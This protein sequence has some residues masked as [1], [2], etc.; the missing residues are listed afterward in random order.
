MMLSDDAVYLYRIWH[1]AEAEA[2]VKVAVAAGAKGAETGGEVVLQMTTGPARTLTRSMREAPVIT[3]VTIAV[4][5]KRGN[6]DETE[7]RVG[8]RAG[9]DPKT[10]NGIEIRAGA[11]GRRRRDNRPELDEFG[12]VI[13]YSRERSVSP[14][15]DRRKFDPRSIRRSE[16][17]DR[18]IEP[19]PA[20]E[21]DAPNPF[22]VESI[23]T[24][25]DALTAVKVNEDDDPET[26]AAK[27]EMEMMA[28]MGIPGCVRVKP[29]RQPRQYMNRRCGFN[30]PLPAEHTR[31]VKGVGSSQYEG[32]NVTW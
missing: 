24:E 9:A 23:F 8:A 20:K 18:D 28:K 6:V 2:G 30:K 15:R 10:G 32:S 11:G 13:D 25:F 31:A 1:E 29:Q 21:V 7:A 12:R 27:M 3:E 26:A 14:D 4:T 16:S 17:P 5:E 19:E 22:Q